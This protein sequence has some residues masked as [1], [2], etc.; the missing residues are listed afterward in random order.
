LLTPKIVEVVSRHFYLVK[1]LR[2]RVWFGSTVYLSLIE[3]KKEKGSAKLHLLFSV[4]E[5]ED[6]FA[7][8]EPQIFIVSFRQWQANE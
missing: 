3:R 7:D 6:Y 1:N 8:M 5:Y 4:E 2:L